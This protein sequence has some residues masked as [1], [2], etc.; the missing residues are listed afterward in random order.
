MEDRL[1]VPV[2]NLYSEYTATG[3]LGNQSL[4][5]GTSELVALD[6]HDG[7]ILW[8][9]ALPSLAFA[10]ATVANDVVLTGTMDGRIRAFD[11]TDGT[12]VWS[13]RTR[14]GLNAPLTVAGDML[15]VPSAGPW[16]DPEAEEAPVRS[17]LAFRLP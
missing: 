17:L 3:Y 9:V 12:P 7:S 4:Y 13:F 1:F 14:S 6:V 8:S 16:L 11:T 5:E 15:L 10:G 2:V